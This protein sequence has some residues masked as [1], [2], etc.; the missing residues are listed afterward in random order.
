[1]DLVLRIFLFRK[2]FIRSTKG[3]TMRSDYLIEIDFKAYRSF[4]NPS[5][6]FGKF[7]FGPSDF[8]SN[9]SHHSTKMLT[10]ETTKI[11]T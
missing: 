3:E 1:M 11:L 8:I 9:R 2:L 4:Q 7:S 5:L 6:S 10:C